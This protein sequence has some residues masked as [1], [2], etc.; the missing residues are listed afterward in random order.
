MYKFNIRMSYCGENK[1][2]GIFELV[3]D[4]VTFYFLDNEYY[5]SGWGPGI[6]CQVP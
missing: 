4:G 6:E 3:Q 2:I 5:F 1:Y